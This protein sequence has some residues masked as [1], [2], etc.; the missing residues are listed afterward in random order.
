MGEDNSAT[1]VLIKAMEE[2]GQSEP[3]SVLVIFVCE[4]GCIKYSSNIDS[5]AMK[6]GMLDMTRELIMR[7]AFGA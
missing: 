7:R 6:L 1:G 5:T 4:D 3:T 2:F